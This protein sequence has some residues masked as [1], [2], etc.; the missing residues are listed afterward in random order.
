M[1]REVTESM[2]G[3][4]ITGGVAVSLIASLGASLLFLLVLH[5]VRGKT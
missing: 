3:V 2:S 1:D 5:L 4:I